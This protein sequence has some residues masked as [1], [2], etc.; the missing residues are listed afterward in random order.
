MMPGIHHL[1]SGK[2]A[3]ENEKAESGVLFD[4]KLWCAHEFS[5]LQI[6]IH[7]GDGE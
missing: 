5:S 4:W 7:M 3:H 6:F 1:G 2:L